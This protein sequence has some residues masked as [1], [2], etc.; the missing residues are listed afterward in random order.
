MEVNH[1]HTFCVKLRGEANAVDEKKE[2]LFSVLG[3]LSRSSPR[4]L[5]KRLVSILR[6]PSRTSARG[7][8]SFLSDGLS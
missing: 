6:K 4:G 2:R 1:F 8:N 3:T 7:L 5:N